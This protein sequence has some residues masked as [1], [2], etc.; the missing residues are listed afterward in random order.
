MTNLNDYRAR[1][2]AAIAYH[3]AIWTPQDSIATAQA[4]AAELANAERGVAVTVP[5]VV[6]KSR[7]F[8]VSRERTAR[9]YDGLAVALLLVVMAALGVI[10]FASSAKADGYLDD[11]EQVYVEMYGELAVCPTITEYRSLAGVM[12]IAEA[13]VEQGFSPD[14]AVDVINASVQAFCPQHWSLLQAIGKASRA[15]D[16]QSVKAKIA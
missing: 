7:L 14:S 9:L 11:D 6:S 12:G 5:K 4:F 16:G 2:A 3:P 13:I 1:K 10:V 8:S 15:A